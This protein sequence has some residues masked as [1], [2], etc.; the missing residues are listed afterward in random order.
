[1]NATTKFYSGFVVV[2]AL[3]LG[4]SFFAG[5]STGYHAGVTSHALHRPIAAHATP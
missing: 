5:Y 2:L 4:L 1:V 3:V